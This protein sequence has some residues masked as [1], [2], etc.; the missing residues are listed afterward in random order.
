MHS[1]TR[2]VLLAGLAALLFG[3]TTPLIPEA[4]QGAGPLTVAGLLYLGASLG[5]LTLGL[6]SRRSSSGR[7]LV[8]S[9]LKT[10]V[11][12]ALFGAALAPTLLVLGL[13]Q[14][15]TIAASLALNAEVFFTVLL[16]IVLYGEPWR[17]RVLFAMLV[18]LAGGVA[19]ALDQVD[20]VGQLAQLGP[21][22]AAAAGTEPSPLLGLALVLGATLS[23]GLDNTLS[24]QVSEV[25][26]FTVVACKGGLGA[27]LTLSL[28]LAFSEP[29]PGLTAVLGLALIGAT[30]YGASL[31]VYLLAQ[32]RLGAA[33]TGSIFG[34]APFIGALVALALGERDAGLWTLVGAG[35]F[36]VGVWVHAREPHAHLHTHPELSHDHTHRHDDGHHDHVHD[37][38]VRGAHSHPHHHHA[39][40]HEH[41]HAPDL[42]HRHPHA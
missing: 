17:G 22:P 42:H 4:A 8:R 15:S 24:R 6:A 5:A 35:L 9:D 18:M 27:T 2:G 34:L 3:V 30:G 33:R 14:T 7:P 31:Y 32:R 11:G 41:P 10:L 26:P 28:A 19:L 1:H 29:A 39:V 16:A 38:P 23:W 40:T 37:P 20:Q 25:R 13:G 12:M 21:A 36:A